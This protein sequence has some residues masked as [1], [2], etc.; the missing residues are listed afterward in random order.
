MSE[1]GTIFLLLKII[2]DGYINAIV[3]RESPVKKPALE[4]LLSVVITLKLFKMEHMNFIWLPHKNNF[5][6]RKLKVVMCYRN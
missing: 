4:Q 3:W 1:S 6:S 5:F 2:I